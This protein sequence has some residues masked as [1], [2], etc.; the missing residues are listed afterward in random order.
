LNLNYFWR[1]NFDVGKSYESTDCALT[2][3]EQKTSIDF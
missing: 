1:L 2:L 3:H